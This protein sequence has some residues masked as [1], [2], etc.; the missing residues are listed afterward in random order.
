[1]KNWTLIVRKSEKHFCLKKWRSCFSS[2]K[3][4]GPC[5]F[6]DVVPSDKFYKCLDWYFL[7]GKSQ[8]YSVMSERFDINFVAIFDTLFEV[9]LRPH[10]REHVPQ[11]MFLEF[12]SE[13]SVHI[14]CSCSALP[15]FPTFP[16]IQ[17]KTYFKA[18]MSYHRDPFQLMG[19]QYCTRSLKRASCNLLAKMLMKSKVGQLFRC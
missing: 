16:S 13:V 2:I 1:M 11:I 14:K 8:K 4:N 10:S 19:R 17:L 5:L 6:N 9:L 7:T 3:S 18:F 12:Q 15:G